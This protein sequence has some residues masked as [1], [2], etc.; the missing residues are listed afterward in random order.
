MATYSTILAWKTHGQGSQACYSAQ[1]HRVRH[2]TGDTTQACETANVS[3]IGHQCQA[4]WRCLPDNSHKTGAPDE[5]IGL[6]LGDTSELQWDRGECKD[7]VPW[8]RFSKSTPE[9]SRRMSNLMCTLKAKA[10]G[11][12]LLHR[13]LCMFLNLLCM[14]CPTQW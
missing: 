4:I 3:P 7:G 2:N 9:T 5:C 6:F 1:G 14:Q 12:G 13:K 11:L 8:P 10:L